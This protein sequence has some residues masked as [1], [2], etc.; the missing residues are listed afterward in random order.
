MTDRSIMHCDGDDGATLRKVLRTKLLRNILK[1]S[2][3][4]YSCKDIP[5]CIPYVI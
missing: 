2:N 4:I 5:R 1:Y 3:Q